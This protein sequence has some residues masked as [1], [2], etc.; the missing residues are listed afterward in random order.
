MWDFELSRFYSTSLADNCK[1]ETTAGTMVTTPPSSPPSDLLSSQTPKEDMFFM[2]AETIKQIM[3]GEWINS[4]GPATTNSGS[5]VKK[6]GG[7]SSSAASSSLANLTPMT[8]YLCSHRRLNPLAINRV[9]LVSRS[10]LEL[11]KSIYSID[12]IGSG[13]VLPAY[14]DQTTRCRVCVRNC[15]AYLRC[16]EKL[17]FDSKLI[18]QILDKDAH[19]QVHNHN[20]EYNFGFYVINLM[21]FYFS[22]YKNEYL[23]DVRE[24]ATPSKRGYSESNGS[25]LISPLRS[26]NG[27]GTSSGD[28]GSARKHHQPPVQYWI[29]KETLRQWP[30]LA[31]RRHESLLP[32]AKFVDNSTDGGIIIEE[33]S[34]EMDGCEIVE[35]KSSGGGMTAEQAATAAANNDTKSSLDFFNQ[36]ILCPHDQLSPTTNKRLVMSS[37]WQ[38]I[39]NM[40]FEDDASSSFDD[41]HIKIFTCQCAECW[42]CQV[43]LCLL[44]RSN[45][46]TIMEIF[47]FG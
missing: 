17:K 1:E 19:D 28:S 5:G 31:L 29:G 26:R 3:S 13:A 36:D 9:K 21:Y 25:T 12:L 7:Q 41:P 16:K 33:M 43:S 18:E 32:S 34:A 6:K 42:Q 30:Q 2:P 8:K 10:G 46:L 44:K 40:Y 23:S 4:G 37:V 14:D 38:K 11:I 27:K 22:I 45:L 39:Y 47:L 24:V 15:V 20:I 35:I